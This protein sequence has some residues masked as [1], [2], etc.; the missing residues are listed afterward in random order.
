MKEWGDGQTVARTSED[1]DRIWQEVKKAE[2]K[3]AEKSLESSIR[4]YLE[5]ELGMNN[6]DSSVSHSATNTKSQNIEEDD[7]SGLHEVKNNVEIQNGKL[8]TYPSGEVV[9]LFVP[10]HGSES[11]QGTE[12]A[13]KLMVQTKEIE[14]KTTQVSANDFSSIDNEQENLSSSP[15]NSNPSRIQNYYRQTVGIHAAVG[16]AAGSLMMALVQKCRR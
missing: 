9:D 6:S 12:D 8:N 16:F 13:L 4:A 1:A 11:N 5:K 3:S 2:K 10:D 14:S 15:A 7:E